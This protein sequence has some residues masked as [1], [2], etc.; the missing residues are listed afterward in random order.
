MLTNLNKYRLICLD[1]DGTIAPRNQIVLYSDVVSTLATYQ[2]ALALTTNQGGPACRDA[3]R[4]HSHKYPTVTEVKTRCQQFADLLEARLYMAFAYVT[5]QGKVLIPK[6]I[7]PTSGP[8][9]RSWRKP[10]PGM[11]LQACRDMGVSGKQVLMVGDRP[12]DQ[13]A[14]HNAGV[15]FR[16][17][18]QVF[19]DER[20]SG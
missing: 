8:A 15:H 19:P 16:W 2:G 5:S 13:A 10:N 17:A 12:E 3:Y 14:A 20:I 11:I 1:I 7:D 18:R 4:K 6:G 9:Q